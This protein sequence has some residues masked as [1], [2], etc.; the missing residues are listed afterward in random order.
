LL[1]HFYKD[2]VIRIKLIETD[3]KHLK[4]AM[5]LIALPVVLESTADSRSYSSMKLEYNALKRRPENWGLVVITKWMNY[6]V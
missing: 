6:G 5:K 2:A 3:N 4:K 1:L